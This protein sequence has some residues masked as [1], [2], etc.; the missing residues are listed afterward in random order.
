VLAWAV[1]R[2]FL[3]FFP[4]FFLTANPECREERHAIPRPH[5][6]SA[7]KSTHNLLSFFG[8]GFVFGFAGWGEGGDSRFFFFFWVF[9]PRGTPFRPRLA[10]P[11]DRHRSLYNVIVPRTNLAS[12]TFDISLIARVRTVPFGFFRGSFCTTLGGYGHEPILRAF[13]AYLVYISC[14]GFF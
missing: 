5:T 8:R 10:R 7:H 12:T 13:R 4:F 6:P 9:G 3:F 2:F 1:C 14:Y 11:P